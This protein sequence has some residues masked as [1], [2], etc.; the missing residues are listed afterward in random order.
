M[1]YKMMHIQGPPLTKQGS[2]NLRESKEVEV[3]E[4]KYCI[5]KMIHRYFPQWLLYKNSLNGCILF[6][7]LPIIIINKGKETLIF[8]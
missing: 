6:L 3:T 2:V 7:L 4:K 5:H 8:G 1:E